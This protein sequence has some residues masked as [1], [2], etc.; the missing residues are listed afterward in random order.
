MDYVLRWLM[1]IVAIIT[2]AGILNLARVAEG[3]LPYG[4]LPLFIVGGACVLVGIACFWPW[5]RH[6]S[7]PLS[8]QT[9]LDN[10]LPAVGTHTPE[11]RPN[12]SALR[13][14]SLYVVASG[15]AISICGFL[16]VRGARFQNRT[17]REMVVGGVV[18]MLMGAAI[19]VSTLHPR[20]FSA[21][22]RA[23]KVI[24]CVVLLAF[25]ALSAVAIVGALCGGW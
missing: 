13:R 6:V 16:G 4:D 23:T 8:D 22:H 2:A 14:R 24:L 5:G 3:N 20:V 10:A 21:A 12:H 11:E 9:D 7:A 25:L 18:V 1:G 19:F 15:G 17:P